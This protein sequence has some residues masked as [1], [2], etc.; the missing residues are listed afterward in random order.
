MIRRFENRKNWQLLAVADLVNGG[1]DTLLSMIPYRSPVLFYSDPPWNP[2]NEKWWRRH[3]GQEPPKAYGE[4]LTEW[5]RCAS[6]TKPF[7]VLCEQSANDKH[8][9]LFTAQV[10]KTS[11][12]NLPLLREYTVHYGSPAGASCRRPN[13]LLHY[14]TTV[15]TTDP[16]GMHGEA[17]TRCVFEGLVFP[18]GTVIVDPCT[19]NGMTSRM[20]HYF[21]CDFV[22]TELNSKR[23]DYTISWLLKHGYK[24][25]AP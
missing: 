6:E 25:V 5:C 11:E 12:W 3:A 16:T 18:T 1:S 14:G 17:M 13:V 2:G 7:A 20:A 9:G 23:L 21:D 15:L 22:G 4:L 24:E 8:R 10:A 19:G